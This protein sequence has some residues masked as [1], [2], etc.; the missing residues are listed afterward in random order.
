MEEAICT[1]RTLEVLGPEHEFSLVNENL[2]VLPIVDKLVKDF[3][4]RIVNFVD[5]GDFSFGK[6]LQLHVLEVK[7]N[8][9]FK[10]PRNF[11]EKMHMAVLRLGE[12]LQKRY[13][14]R[15][16]GTGMHPKLR[17]EETTVWP[18]RHRQIYEAFS[19]IFN[20]KQHGWLNIQSFQLNIPYSDEEK[21]VQ[22]HNLLA[23][24][25]AYL[26]AV[27]ASSPI[28]EGCFGDYVDN[29]LYFYME[30]Q[31]EIPSITG[32]VVPEYVYS[33][34]QYR[35][36][37]IE[38]YSSDLAKAGAHQCIL[39]KE[40]VN[41]RGVILRFERKAVE[42]R[43]MDEQECIKSDVAL[44]CFIRALLR[45]LMAENAPLM[46][47]RLLT[48]D[49][50]SVIKHGLNAKVLHPNGP[51]ARQVCEHFLKI[52]WESATVEEKD[53]LPLVQRRIEHGN[54]AEVIR[55]KIQVRAQKTDLNEA[56]VD[57]YSKLL[58]SLIDNE[59]FF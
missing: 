26:P 2:K 59:P 54:L 31:K 34:K 8:K 37:V 43:V 23:N 20:L 22:V 46:P 4:G 27:S 3:Y 19:R 55:E 25:C 38:K 39:N 58:K 41:S 44:S 52:A 28:Y 40:W 24:V 35:K 49:F 57:V 32:N 10:S 16:L 30:N 5:F 1:Y 50:K 11:E 42:I 13:G 17:L 47:T 15:L 9:P 36:D 14:A 7:P 18:H 51:T 29:R 56:I 12:L 33:F 48:E 6:E 21:A 53:Y 45:G